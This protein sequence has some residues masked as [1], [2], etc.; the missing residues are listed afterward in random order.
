LTFPGVI[1]APLAVGTREGLVEITNGSG[2]TLTST[3]VNGFV[4][5]AGVPPMVQ[6]STN[7]LD[8]YT[9]P[10]GTTKTLPLTVTNIGGGTLTIDPTFSGHSYTISENTC[11]GGLKTG[12]SCILRVQFS[13]TSSGYDDEVLTLQT[14][15]S[16]NPT[17]YLG[18]RAIGL[19]ISGAPL[20][21]GTVPYGS[22]V[23]LPPTVT[24]FRCAGHGSCFLLH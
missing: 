1:F 23:V 11:G 15:V 10:T 19:R 16:P 7:H 3:T 4:P 14:N 21:F 9:I 17:V 5:V 20:E 6:L 13:P 18:G 12:N 8:F 22:T 2:T 24:N